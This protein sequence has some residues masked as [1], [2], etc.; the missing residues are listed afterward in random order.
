MSEEVCSLATVAGLCHEFAHLSSLVR[1]TDGP[2]NAKQVRRSYK[3]QSPLLFI[4]KVAQSKE[5]S[6]RVAPAFQIVLI[7]QTPTPAP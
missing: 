3:T 1:K 4:A 2:M 6:W 7:T 5:V